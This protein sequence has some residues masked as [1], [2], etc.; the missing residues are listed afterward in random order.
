MTAET[1]EE[2][3]LIVNVVV[4]KDFAIT[5][6][7]DSAQCLIQCSLMLYL[8]ES[9]DEDKIR[10]T[11]DMTDTNDIIFFLILFLYLKCFDNALCHWNFA[12]TSFGFGC[13]DREIA[14]MLITM[15]VIDQRMVHVDKSC[16]EIHITPAQAGNLANTHPGVCHDIKD[17][18]PVIVA[19]RIPE[20]FKEDPFLLN[21]QRLSLFHLVTMCR[22]QLTQHIVG[23]VIPNHI[24]I[25][26]D[27]KDLMEH[28]MNTVQ[29]RNFQDTLINKLIVESAYI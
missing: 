10:I 6:A 9:V 26:C 25:D 19:W 13:I 3:R 4:F 2:H 7:H 5:I 27:G 28:V 22:F 15:I 12:D 20:I 1:W 18:I 11:F 21:G 14:A 8:S 29:G 23:R 24:I 17:R 16:L